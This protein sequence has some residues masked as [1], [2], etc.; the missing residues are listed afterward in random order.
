MLNVQLDVSKAIDWLEALPQSVHDALLES[1]DALRLLLEDKVVNDKLSGQVLNAKTGALQR[2][3]VSGLND[4]DTAVYGWVGSS[5]DVSYA[6]IQEFGGKTAAHDIM[7]DKA[8]ALAFLVG[9]KKIF[10]KIVHHPGSVIPERS[11]LRS[12]LAD[13]EDEIVAEATEAVRTG[14]EQK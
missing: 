4:D 11:Y 1:M 10:A 12:A 6:A 2:S 3:I 14:L 5:G 13:M 8:K 9:G 7:P